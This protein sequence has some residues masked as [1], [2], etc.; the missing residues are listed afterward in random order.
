MGAKYVIDHKKDLKEELKSLGIESIKQIG[1]LY[2]SDDYAEFLED[3]ITPQGTI[4]F[5][6]NNERPMGTAVFKDKSITLAWEMRFT[7][8]KYH[9]PDMIE[10]HHILDN[11]QQ[12]V[13]QG[14]IQH[15]MTRDMGVLTAEVATEGIKLLKEQKQV[16]KM[17]ARIDFK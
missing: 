7:R 17:T 4:G 1:C 15:T 13:E 11:I 2:N 10:Q 16:G 3:I 14:K 12:F 6:V 8:V 5:I 9:T